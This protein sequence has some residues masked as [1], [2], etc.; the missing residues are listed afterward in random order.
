MTTYLEANMQCFLMVIVS[1]TNPHLARL[2][3][4]ENVFVAFHSHRQSSFLA[5]I[6]WNVET[7]NTN[8]ERIPF[9]R[10]HS[11]FLLSSLTESTTA[12]KSE[13]ISLPP[14]IFTSWWRLGFLYALG[15]LCCR[16]ITYMTKTNIY[17]KDVYFTS[18]H[19]S[20]PDSAVSVL[21]TG[22]RYIV[23]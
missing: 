4:N 21:G 20:E 1:R 2:W 3:Q 9:L 12:C 22:H 19:Q 15:I 8:V 7:N 5:E 18:K 17:L 11:N 16:C 13:A 6:I 23:A 14:P 10:N